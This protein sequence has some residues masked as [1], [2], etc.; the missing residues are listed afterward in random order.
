MN[1]HNH[2]INLSKFS[3][4]ITVPERANYLKKK[5]MPITHIICLQSSI[6]NHAEHNLR[7][8]AAKAKSDEI[9]AFLTKRGFKYTVTKMVMEALEDQLTEFEKELAS[10]S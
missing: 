2:P 8:E 4:F 7:V 6:R 10:N 1:Y 5:K 9:R 3:G